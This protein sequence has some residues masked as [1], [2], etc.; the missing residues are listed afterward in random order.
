MLIK[1]IAFVLVSCSPLLAQSY[2]DKLLEELAEKVA[3]RTAEDPVA[4][5]L[6]TEQIYYL[7][8]ETGHQERII[9]L[10]KELYDKSS[11]QELRAE[12]G[13]FLAQYQRQL[14][15]YDAVEQLIREQGYVSSWRIVGPLD[16][17]EPLDLKT[18]WRANR[19]KGLDREVSPQIVPAYGSGDFWTRGMGHYGY[20]NTNNAVYPNQLAGAFLTTWFQLKETT[21]VRL[22]LGWDNIAKV[23]V[24]KTQILDDQANQAPHPDQEVRTFRLKK[25]WHRLSVFVASDSDEPNLGIY[26]RLTDDQGKP[27]L[28]QANNKKRSPR[29][30]PEIINNPQ[31]SL[32]E[33]ARAKSPYALGSIILL[34]EQTLRNENEAPRDLFAKALEQDGVS[35]LLADKLVALNND[36]NERW[37]ILTDLLDNIGPEAK[38]DRAWALSQLGQIALAQARFWEARKYAGLALE[39]APDYWPAQVLENNTLSNLRLDGQALRQTLELHQK[40]PNVPWVMMDLSDLYSEMDYREESRRLT[41]E[42]LEI[43]RASTKFAERKIKMLKRAGELDQLK[44]FYGELLRDSPYSVNTTLAFSQFLMVNGEETKAEKLL[45]NYLEILPE[46]PFLLERMGE[47]KLR[48]AQKREA[49]PYLEKSL[50]LRP[51]N[52]DLEKLIA[53]TKQGEGAFYETYRIAETPTAEIKERSPIVV[54]VD[55]TVI[56]V[57]PN[58]QSSTFH[59]LEWEI[60]TDQGI[61]EL[62]GYSFSYAPLRQEA[63]IVLAEVVRGDRVIHMTRF[64]RARISD[65]AYRMYYDLVAYQIAFPPLEIGDVVRV[66]YRI[67]DTGSNN[68]FGDYFG[69]L[70]YFSDRYPTR[71]K[72][73]TLIVPS[74]RK[75]HYHVE[76]MKPQFNQQQV[77][78]NQVYS[79][80]LSSVSPYESESRMPGLAGYMPYVA[81]S[82][83]NNWQDMASWYAELIEDQLNLDSETRALV[84]QL[85]KGMT[86]RLE[87]VKKIHEYVVTNTRYVALEFGIHGYKPYEVNSVSSRQFGDCKDKASLIVSMLQEAGIPAQIS[88]V[89]TVDK[90]DVHTFPAML[91][92]FNHAIAY[93]PEFD[94]YLD[95]T[96]EFSGINELPAMDQGALTLLVDDQGVGKLTKIPISEDNTQNYA[97]SFEVQPNGTTDVNGSLSY[98][99]VAT[100]RLREYLSIETKLATNLQN[101]M[102][103]T[104]PGL[105]VLEANREGYTINDPITLRFSGRTSQLLQKAG[106]NYSLPLRILGDGLTQEYAANATRRFPIEF[107]VPKTRSV[108]L[109]ISAPEGFTLGSLPEQLTIEDENVRLSLEV[110]KQNNRSCRIEYQVAFKKHRVEPE[111]YPALRKLLQE[112]DR[113]LDQSIQFVAP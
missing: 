80:S 77:D 19:I 90:G 5:L 98:N 56:K 52:P 92:Y 82:T 88:I 108:E 17:D 38:F 11:H 45:D 113:V 64:G 87:I 96:A 58:G 61:K 86:D 99:G 67:D 37:E 42:V 1:F 85:T 93:V 54:N 69:D 105:D 50:A 14:G 91:A 3:N 53:Y 28:T 75:I 100:P 83:F 73:Y 101:L 78:Q 79:W 44:A 35:Q 97:L 26:A 111:A 30:K 65:P 24:N 21:T 33:L 31:K 2:A 9:S 95:G 15:H 103:E 25:G 48:T 60:L 55:N 112:H 4:D 47:L 107:G 74:E 106:D 76:R 94:L 18:L 84:K 22:G 10:L 20:F 7:G 12:V 104:L 39:Q 89:R 66:E 49:L 51:Q 109:N 27:I 57:S 13:F 70:Q 62:P 63:E 29:K 8:H 46:N 16:P 32:T 40:Y 34:K 36:P 110:V 43:R 59:Q 102:R 23:W 81:V 68:I 6:L 72:N 41:E 71:L